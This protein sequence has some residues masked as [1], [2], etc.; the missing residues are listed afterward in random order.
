MLNDEFINPLMASIS[1]E[2][3]RFTEPQPEIQL[4]KVIKKQGPDMLVYELC[5]GQSDVPLLS[6]C[7][8]TFDSSEEV[9]FTTIV[10]AAKRTFREMKGQN[11][12]LNSVFLGKMRREGFFGINFSVFDHKNH[13]LATINFNATPF[14]SSPVSFTLVTYDSPVIEEL[15]GSHYGLRGGGERVYAG[16]ICQHYLK[17]VFRTKPPVWNT[18]LK[19]WLH[20]LGAR[21]RMSSNNNFVVMRDLQC[22]D[23][24]VEAEMEQSDTSTIR[25]T[26]KVCLRH[27]KD[28]PA[29]YIL[30]YRDVS[31]LV[32]LATVVAV[33]LDKD[34]WVV[35]DG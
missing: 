16:P 4:C 28:G 11:N 15:N 18:E 26:D 2:K 33:L 9:I 5:R 25:G 31:P 21:V 6:A 13:R 8:Y 23:E 12:V 30:D 32:A 35:T 1:E 24:S 7:V 34:P 10:D 20:N 22:C 17:T 19:T 3:G 27:G 29:S 14:K